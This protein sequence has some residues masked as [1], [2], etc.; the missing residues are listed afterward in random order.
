MTIQHVFYIPT[1]FLLGLVSGIILNDRRRGISAINS[2]DTDSKTYQLRHQTSGRNLFQTFLVLLLVFVITHIFEMPW[3]LKT[4]SQLLG[5]VEIFD[6]SPVF[7]SSEVYMRLNQFS[8]EG[9]KTYK[10]F[11]YTTDVVFPLSL[12]AFLS[13]LAQYVSQ[14]KKINRCLRILLSG[15]PFFWFACDMVENA[16]I[17]TILSKYPGQIMFLADSLGYITAVKFVLLLLSLFMPTLLYIFSK[18]ELV[19]KKNNL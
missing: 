9:L 3:G 16:V 11:T 6:R 17:F 14:R 2:R 7:S 10:R 5:G 1:I 13:T 12:L 18:K 19:Q 15:L 4:V 8:F